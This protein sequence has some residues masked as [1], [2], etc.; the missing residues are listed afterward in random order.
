LLILTT[1]TEHV[2]CQERTDFFLLFWGF[3][4]NTHKSKGKGYPRT[5]HEGPEGSIG[6]VVLFISPRLY[7]LVGGQRHALATLPPG[8]PG[9]PLYKKEYA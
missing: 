5:G 8:M 7:V 1:Q 9:Y 3:C 2:S 6:I 4:L